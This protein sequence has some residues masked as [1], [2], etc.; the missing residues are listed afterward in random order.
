[1][2]TA[3]MDGSAWALPQSRSASR[4]FG[5][6]LGIPLA[7]QEAQASAS[8]LGTPREDRLSR[9]LAAVEAAQREDWDGEGCRALRED[10]IDRAPSMIDLVPAHMQDPDISVSGLGSLMF[11]WD[12][13]PDWQLSLALSPRDT[14]SFAGFFR[15]VRSHG[16]F[17]F[18]PERLPD[19]IQTAFKR[20][21]NR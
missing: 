8:A 19:E 12:D 18:Y 17:P 3:C 11:D 10:A 21:S 13:G 15:G 7:Q 16:E 14:I 5:L 1:M 4:L 20:W 9:L 2:T 6:S